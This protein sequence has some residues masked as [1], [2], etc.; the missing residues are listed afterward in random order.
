[1]LGRDKTFKDV[2]D[3]LRDVSDETIIAVLADKGYA[4]ALIPTDPVAPDDVLVTG[5]AR[6]VGQGGRPLVGVQVAVSSKVSAYSVTSPSTQETF[7]PSQSSVP[8][9]VYSDAQGNVSV[10]LF[11]GSTVYVRSGLSSVVREIIVPDSD[12]SLYDAGVEVGA[13]LYTD[14]EVA[15]DYTLRRDV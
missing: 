11:K 10:K 5:S 9:L 12:F 4:C 3:Y 6:F 7:R 8:T 1:M 14:I 2:K 13:D 15:K